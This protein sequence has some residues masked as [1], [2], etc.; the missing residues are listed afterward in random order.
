V[1]YENSG[2]GAAVMTNAQGGG[3]LADEVMRSIAAAYDW[4][5]FRDH[6]PVAR[7]AVKV[8]PSIL[9]RY[10]GTYDL[11]DAM[12]MVKISIALDNGRLTMQSAGE[13]KNVM[14]AESETKFFLTKENVEMEFKPNRAGKLRY[15]VIVRD[16]RETIAAKEQ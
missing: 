1:G 12:P 15:L 4:P 5:D 13:E 8:D 14:F 11:T 7:A 16:G 10:V 3:R 9:E 6:P 2:D